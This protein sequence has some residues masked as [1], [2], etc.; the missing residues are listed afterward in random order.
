MMTQPRF[1]MTPEEYHRLMPP[2]VRVKYIEGV[3]YIEQLDSKK[4]L[5]MGHAKRPRT[6]YGWFKYHV[7]HGLMMGFPLLPV[8]WYAWRNRSPG[9]D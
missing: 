3:V 4:W 7:L 6:K 5:H 8:L 2:P 1:E 9:E